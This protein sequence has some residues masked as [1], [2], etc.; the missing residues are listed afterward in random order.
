[1]FQ[2]PSQIP[3][4]RFKP[5]QVISSLIGDEGP[6][7]LL[8]YLKQKGWVTA[9]EKMDKV[10]V[11]IVDKTGTITEGKP[12]VEKVGSFVQEYK[13]EEIL[14]Y[15]LSVNTNSEHPL[16]E[17]TLKYGKERGIKPLKSSNFKS[18][19]IHF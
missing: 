19:N 5:E 11:L 12:T 3:F 17:A 10:N 13:S 2:I 9:L 7:S 15:I 6:G 4:Y 16:A 14:L 8:S 1:M 18:I